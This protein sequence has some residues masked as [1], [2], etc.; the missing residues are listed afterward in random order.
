MCG[1]YVSVHKYG[2]SGGLKDITNFTKWPIHEKLS[3]IL[4][5][6]PL[7]SHLECKICLDVLNNPVQTSCCG[8][9]YWKVCISKIKKQV[10]PHCTCCENL[11]IFPD[12]KYEINE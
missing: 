10:Y 5:T 8:Q 3:R 6:P 4:F 7:P 11:E 12:K 2:T 1:L 9:S